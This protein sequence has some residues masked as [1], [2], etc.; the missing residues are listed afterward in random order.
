M[1]LKGGEGSRKQLIKNLLRQGRISLFVALLSFFGGVEGKQVQS[2]AVKPVVKIPQ[3]ESKPFIGAPIAPKVPQVAPVRVVQAQGTSD[4]FTQTEAFLQLTR[5]K[6]LL[7][8]ESSSRYIFLILI[9]FLIA[10]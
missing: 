6:D 1:H 3:I 7:T 4:Q 10:W 2:G 5:I 8:E 9:L